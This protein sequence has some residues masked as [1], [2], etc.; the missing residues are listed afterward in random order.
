[1]AKDG[2]RCRVGS[3]Q[4]WEGETVESSQ[5]SGQSHLDKVARPSGWRGTVETSA[6]RIPFYS[7]YA[8][9]GGLISLHTLDKGTEWKCLPYIWSC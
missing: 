7:A 4:M 1:M 5:P 9:P 6:H 3:L 2:F 8:D